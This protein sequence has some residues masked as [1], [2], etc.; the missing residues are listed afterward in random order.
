MK[1]LVSYISSKLNI[2]ETIKKID[3]STC[4]GI[5]VDLMDGL[6]V[7]NKNTLP[8]LNNISKPLDIHLMVNN[9]EKYF[10]ILLK[11]KPVCIYIH[12]STTNNPIHLF[13]YLKFN[14]I[15]SGIAIN[16]NEDISSFDKYFPYI[17]RVLLMSVYPGLGGQEFI[18]STKDRLKELIKY[19][20]KYNFEIYID[21]GINEET[22]KEVLK[23][24]GVVSG[25]FI[26]QSD[27]YNKQIN[28]LRS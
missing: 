27:D 2:D 16:P 23:A 8:N 9:P 3:N 26:C 4:D 22:I 19:K 15:A 5:H 21:G 11:L 20:E 24:D 7:K 1:I 14:N 18:P 17:T 28:K 12:P 10:D 25:T 13:N 6:Y